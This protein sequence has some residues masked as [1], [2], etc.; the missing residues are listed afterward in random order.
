MLTG[1][2]LEVDGSSH[3]VQMSD[4]TWI[5][6]GK[7]VGGFFEIVRLKNIYS[8]SDMVVCVNDCGAIDNLPINQMASMICA[9]PIFGPAVLLREGFVDGEPDLISLDDEDLMLCDLFY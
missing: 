6:L 2:K 5:A 9:Q 7:E 3:E 4:P 1:W 8:G